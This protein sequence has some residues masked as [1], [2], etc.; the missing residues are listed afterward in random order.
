MSIKS[1]ASFLRSPNFPSIQRGLP[2]WFVAPKPAT[3]RMRPVCLSGSLGRGWLYSMLCLRFPSHSV[4]LSLCPRAHTRM[5]IYFLMLCNE[6]MMCNLCVWDTIVACLF[7]IQEHAK[8]CGSEFVWRPP[9]SRKWP[10]RTMC[11]STMR[12]FFSLCRVRVKKRR[13]EKNEEDKINCKMPGQ[14]TRRASAVGKKRQMTLTLP[15]SLSKC[16]VP[17]SPIRQ[18]S[19]L[20]YCVFITCWSGRVAAL[21]AARLAH[22]CLLY[23]RSGQAMYVPVCADCH[24]TA[25]YSAGTYSLVPVHTVVYRSALQGSMGPSGRLRQGSKQ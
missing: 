13:L 7:R 1:S 6:N 22:P 15:L 20:S 4:S 21:L 17:A 2:Q 14:A 11:A 25:K 24:V 18:E 8:A 10:T 12:F 5:R 3:L 19:H 9:G 16:S 23:V